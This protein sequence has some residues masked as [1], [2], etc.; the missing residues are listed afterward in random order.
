VA[1]LQG[2]KMRPSRE[3]VLRFAQYPVLFILGKKDSLI[4]WEKMIPQ[5]EIPPHKQVLLLEDAAHMG[6]YEAPRETL[7]TLRGFAYKCFREKV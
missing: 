7:K 3:I 5:T 2:M 1:A 6:F 4:N